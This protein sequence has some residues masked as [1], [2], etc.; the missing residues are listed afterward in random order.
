MDTSTVIEASG[1][2]PG[3]DASMPKV[4]RK[5]RRPN[6]VTMTAWLRF[7]RSI[8]PRSKQRFVIAAPIAPA[9]CGRRSVQSRQSRQKR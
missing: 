1:W 6:G 7:V 2:S 4:S 8:Q 3:A 9:L 5:P